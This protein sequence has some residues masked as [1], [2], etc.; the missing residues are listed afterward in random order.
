M[1]LDEKDETSIV[2]FYDDFAL[3]IS[4]SYIFRA[5]EVV[6]NS[7]V[8]AAEQSIMVHYLTLLF[9]M[10]MFSTT[11]ALET[12]EE[13]MVP[14]RQPKLFWVSSSATTSSVST[15]TIC[16]VST[17]TGFTT[18]K[19]RKRRNILADT[20]TDEDVEIH[21]QSTLSKDDSD[22]DIESGAED[23]ATS[24]RD[25]RFLLYWLTTTT[26]STTTIYTATGTL[27]TLACTPAGY[28][29]SACG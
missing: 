1:V 16:F 11:K 4:G 20:I 22:A 27:A 6:F 10:I 21:P 18:C 29:V 26:T 23:P 12:E 8:P 13:K 28:T 2:K 19:K 5:A 25:G 9:C 14:S 24:R 15:S 17:A 7:K 3:H